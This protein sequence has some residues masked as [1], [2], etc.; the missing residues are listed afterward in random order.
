MTRTTGN[1]SAPFT[2]Y[3]ALTTSSFQVRARCHCVYAYLGC[4]LY[5]QVA[6]LETIRVR[7]TPQHPADISML[8]HV[9]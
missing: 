9:D 7:L 5:L 4:N 8:I 3:M 1:I 6:I 2:A